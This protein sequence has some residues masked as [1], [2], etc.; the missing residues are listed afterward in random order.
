MSEKGAKTL[1]AGLGHLGMRDKGFGVVV[2]R[3]LQHLQLPETVELFEGAPESDLS[4]VIANRQNVIMVD[5]VDA[6]GDP[7]NLLVLSPGD[8]LNGQTVRLYHAEIVKTLA[9]TYLMGCAPLKVR[10]IGVIPLDCSPGQDLSE[11]VR[12][13]MP[14]VIDAI[15]DEVRNNH[16]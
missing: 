10:V 14:A 6:A 9:L 12:R 4:D 15:L 7:A 11:P 8:F 3:A 1:I 16:S 2:I 13:Q 5:L